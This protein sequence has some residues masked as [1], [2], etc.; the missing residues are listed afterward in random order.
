[1]SNHHTS[2]G[3][4]DEP[5]FICSRISTNNED[6]WVAVHISPFS[7][8]VGGH[9][10]F[11]E[12]RCLSSWILYCF[13]SFK[14]VWKW[15]FIVMPLQHWATGKKNNLAVWPDWREGHTPYLSSIS[16][17][18]PP[19]NSACNQHLYCTS[20]HRGFACQLHWHKPGNIVLA[21]IFSI[22][23]NSFFFHLYCIFVFLFRAI[24]GRKL[25]LP[26]L[27]GFFCLSQ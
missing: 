18:L 26:L 3:K 20:A 11:L 10:T 12:D 2:S 1:M 27:Q 4:A 22:H 16:A 5:E 8:G 7:N 23:I 17:F 6:E 24:S 15:A 14:Y 21:I 9:H 13:P 25:T 19:F